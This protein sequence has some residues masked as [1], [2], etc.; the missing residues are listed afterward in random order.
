MYTGLKNFSIL[1]NRT[2]SHT[3][4]PK[5]VHVSGGSEGTEI[6]RQLEGGNGSIQ[7]ADM[8]NQSGVSDPGIKS[9]LDDLLPLGK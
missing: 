5:N 8:S 3:V 1:C 2:S 6:S 7:A 9:I 4:I